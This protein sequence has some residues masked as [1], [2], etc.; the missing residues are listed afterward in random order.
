MI[1]KVVINLKTGLVDNPVYPCHK[2]EG[3]C[4]LRTTDCDKP[5]C[6]FDPEDCHYRKLGKEHAEGS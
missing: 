1:E 6:A 4:Q 3:L 5:D 2:G